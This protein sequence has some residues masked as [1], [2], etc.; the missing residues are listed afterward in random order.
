MKMIAESRPVVAMPFVHLGYLAA[1]FSR[2]PGGYMLTGCI[3]LVACLGMLLGCRKSKI[4]PTGKRVFL[5][6]TGCI[7]VA[8]M[9]VGASSPHGDELTPI[10]MERV[11]RNIEMK[12]NDTPDEFTKKR[13]NP[14]KS[15]PTQAGEHDLAA[16][17]Q[18]RQERETFTD[19]WDT[20]MRLRVVVTDEQK[21]DYVLISAGEDREWN[22]K[23]DSTS[24]KYPE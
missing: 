24:R 20:P 10:R 5:Y 22:T 17:V 18:D 7:V 4:G 3:L 16:L 15:L 13:G 6:G 8:W 9:F 2:P 11:L 1:S 23:D 14:I 19:G 21:P 12:L